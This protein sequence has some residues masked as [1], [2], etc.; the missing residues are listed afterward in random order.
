MDQPGEEITALEFEEMKKRYDNLTSAKSVFNED[1][2]KSV[3]FGTEV[4]VKLIN[5]K[6]VTGIRVHFGINKEG[7][8]TVMLTGENE[9]PH[10][11]ILDRGQLCPPY[12]PQ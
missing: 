9:D 11:T 4:F 6:G 1:Q 3:L 7:K 8:L 5:T 2:T 10:L 12:C